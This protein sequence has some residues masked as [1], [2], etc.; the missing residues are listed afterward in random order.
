MIA[1]SSHAGLVGN[2]VARLGELDALCRRAIAALDGNIA[3]ADALPKDLFNSQRHRSA[4]LASPHHINVRKIRQ[5]V[6]LTATVKG[7]AFATQCPPNCLG[8]VDGRQ[9]CFEDAHHRLAA[10][11]AQAGVLPQLRGDARHAWVPA[12][13][14]ANWR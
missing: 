7:V 11:P 8:R 14:P 12:I 2:G 5:L 9:S 13:S 6:A 10:L 4:G 1:R 3:G